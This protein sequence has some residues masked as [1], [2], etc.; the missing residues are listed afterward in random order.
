MYKSIL[1]NPDMGHITK[2]IETKKED[3]DEI[4]I[5]IRDIYDKKL[6]LTIDN[7]LQLMKQDNENYI[8]YMNAINNSFNPTNC[9]IQKWI[10]EHIAF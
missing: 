3:I 6:L 2:N 9:N 4:F 7:L 1:E 10:H 5:N 8:S